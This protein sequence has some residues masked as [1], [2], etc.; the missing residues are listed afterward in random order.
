MTNNN[1][2]TRLNLSSKRATGHNM[3][4]PI[5]GR[6]YVTGFKTI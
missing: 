5:E 1:V 3:C 6:Q 2:L 4:F